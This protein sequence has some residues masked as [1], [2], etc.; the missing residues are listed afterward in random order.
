MGIVGWNEQTVAGID[1]FPVRIS[2]AVSHPG[3]PASPKD[4]LNRSNQATCRLAHNDRFSA[5]RVDVWFAIRNY[6]EA[7]VFQASTHMDSQTIGSP[8]R[9]ACSAKPRFQFGRGA[10]TIQAFSEG[11]DFACKRTK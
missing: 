9:L 11:R 7:A 3:S 1:R 10:G 5:T 6:K 8:Q 4:R 2:G